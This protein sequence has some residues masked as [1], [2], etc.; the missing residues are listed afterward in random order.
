MQREAGRRRGQA[1]AGVQERDHHGHV[2]AAD[3]EH[4][5]DAEG[6]RSQD[7]ADEQPLRLGSG[8]DGP[9]STSATAITSAF[10]TFCPG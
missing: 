3:R 2:G 6:E 10:T 7:H 1:G 4:E 8:E 9:A 5:E